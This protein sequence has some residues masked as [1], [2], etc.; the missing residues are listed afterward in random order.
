MRRCASVWCALA[1]SESS[2]SLRGRRSPSRPPTCTNVSGGNRLLDVHGLAKC[3][4]D[5]VD[6]LIA[7]DPPQ[8]APPLVALDYRQGVAQV[9]GDAIGDNFAF[10][11]GAMVE[12]AATGVNGSSVCGRIEVLME[13]RL[14]ARSH[15]R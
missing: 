11:I 13:A 15:P 12:L 14:A 3:P 10:V 4:F 6:R 5:C 7:I 8:D 1:V 9:D 2:A